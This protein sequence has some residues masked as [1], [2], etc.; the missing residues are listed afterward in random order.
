MRLALAPLLVIALLLGA[1]T[2]SCAEDKRLAEARSLVTLA[3]MLIEVGADVGDDA[4]VAKGVAKLREAKKLFEA[5]LKTPELAEPEKNRIKA[6]LVDLESRIDWHAPAAAAGG[7]RAGDGKGGF[8][9]EVKIPPLLRGERIAAWCKRVRKVYDGTDDAQGQAALARGLATQGGVNALPTLF[10]LFVKEDTPAARIG[11][12]EA[13]ATVGTYRVANKMAG[14]ASKSKEAHWK[15]ALE[16]IYLCLEKS[17]KSEPEAPYLRAIRAFH[18][19]KI[20][21][22]SLRILEHLDAM[23]TDGVAALGEIVYVDDFGYHDHTIGLLAKKQDRRA[24]PPL[25]YKMNRFKFEGRVQLPAHHA[26]IKIGWYA[27]PELVERLNDKSAGIWV[28]WTL[29]KI[30]GETMGTDRRKWRD[31]WKNE[32]VRHPELFDD[33]E[34][35]PGGKRDPVTT[36]GGK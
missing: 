7:A 4:K 3:K 25:V 30:T 31:W 9:G 5:V 10:D 19:L 35:R 16:V 13:L 21:K 8:S 22:L 12:H 17:D 28:S 18:K 20:R 2:A 34:E 23:G 6:W 33:P 1:R 32:K 15:R 27:V 24:V 26:L 11:V 14:Y 36:G 29:R